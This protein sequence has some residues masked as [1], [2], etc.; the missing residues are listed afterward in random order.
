MRVKVVFLP[1]CLLILSLLK[2]KSVGAFLSIDKI[3]LFIL[4]FLKYLP[5]MSMLGLQANIIE[6][7]RSSLFSA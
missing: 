4:S 5:L 7:Q 2:H 3:I 1:N 6:K